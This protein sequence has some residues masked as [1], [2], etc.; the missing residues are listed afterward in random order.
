MFYVC[1]CVAEKVLGFF[2]ERCGLRE[3]VSSGRGYSLVHGVCSVIISHT[4]ISLISKF[5]T[6]LRYGN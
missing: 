2:D 3:K 1:V 4:S 6:F 5:L